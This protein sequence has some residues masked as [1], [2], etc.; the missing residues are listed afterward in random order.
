MREIIS[1]FL[2]YYSFNTSEVEASLLAL[3]VFS[4]GVDEFKI[5]VLTDGGQY[6]VSQL[7]T[8]VIWKDL[9]EVRI[10]AD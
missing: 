6:T 3:L 5:Q 7:G 4:K 1:V 10:D 9:T 2:F 8:S